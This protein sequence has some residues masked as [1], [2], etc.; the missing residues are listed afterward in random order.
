N[1]DGVGPAEIVTSTGVLAFDGGQIRKIWATD[2]PLSNNYTILS[3]MIPVDLDGD[4]VMEV[5]GDSKIYDGMTGAVKLELPTLAFSA[6]ADFDPDSPG[7]EIVRVDPDDAEVTVIAG[8]TAPQP[9]KVLFGPFR[10][11]GMGP[12]WN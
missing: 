9:G 6:V 4:G 1:V 5:I 10:L 3:T 11:P 7:A 12:Q 2:T 8:L